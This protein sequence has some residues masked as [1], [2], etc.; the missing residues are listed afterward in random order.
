MADR[1]QEPYAKDPILFY[2]GR[3]LSDEEW[4][5]FVG[6]TYDTSCG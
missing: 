4:K 1:K 5:S 6:G 2:P 3:R